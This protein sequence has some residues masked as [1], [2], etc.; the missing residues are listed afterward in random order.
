MRLD[1]L[2][3]HL[4]YGSRKEVKEYIRKGFVSVNGVV[5]RNDDLKIDEEKDEV[6]FLEQ[7][8]HY[9][10]YLYFLLN[11]P[12]GYISA[13]CD[14]H[15]LTVLDLIEGHETR[16]LFPVGRLDKDTTGLLLITND[17]QLAHNLL[18]P[19]KHVD[20]V[21]ELTFKGV[22]KKEY[23]SYFEEGIILDDGYKC[24]S[25]S[26]QLLSQ[27]CGRISIQEG[28]YHQVKRMMQALN[29]EVL[30]LKRISFGDLHLPSDL[31]EGEYIELTS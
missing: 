5:V 16:G 12:A 15:E 28:K 17:G 21:Y 7:E 20:K 30:S 31:K 11:K 26:F 23:F 3:A 29:M 6:I 22:F 2:L 19:S 10:K 14:P 18:S 1:K 27:N 4:G 8:I 13:T 9:E 24:K 25:A